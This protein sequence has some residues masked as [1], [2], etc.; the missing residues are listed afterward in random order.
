MRVC[1]PVYSADAH[2]H[3][4]SSPGPLGILTAVHHPR[5]LPKDNT[6]IHA[7]YYAHTYTHTVYSVESCVLNIEILQ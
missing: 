7:E 6:R 2:T 4:G 1:T 5:G 3:T